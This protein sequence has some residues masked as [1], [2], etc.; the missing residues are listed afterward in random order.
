VN[1]PGGRNAPS[2]F[3]GELAAVCGGAGETGCWTAGVPPEG[4]VPGAADPATAPPAT[5]PPAVLPV[6][7][8]GAP[9][10][11]DAE[12]PLG[13][14]LLTGAPLPPGDD[15]VPPPAVAGGFVAGLLEVGEE[16]GGGTVE[17]GSGGAEPRPS[18][19]VH[20]IVTCASSGC[21]G[22]TNARVLDVCE[23]VSC[24]WVVG[25]SILGNCHSYTVITSRFVAVGTPAVTN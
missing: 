4:A 19:Q 20:V 9:A 3:V 14:G 13:G 5:P 22:P 24:V 15:D 7:A 12:A 16:G 6:G 25:A 21:S 10:L 1:P 8:A 18:A 23:P 2:E 17:G 11:P